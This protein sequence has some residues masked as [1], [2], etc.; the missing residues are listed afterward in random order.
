MAAKL[1]LSI[2]LL[3]CWPEVAMPRCR[4]KC[5]LYSGLLTTGSSFVGEEEVDIDNYLSLSCELCLR[6]WRTQDY[7]WPH[8]C[9]LRHG[10]AQAV[11]GGD[12]SDT[13]DQSPAWRNYCGSQRTCFSV[14]HIKKRWLETAFLR[15][16]PVSDA[17]LSLS[18]TSYSPA[19]QMMAGTFV[20]DV[21]PIG[22][23]T[24][25]QVG[26]PGLCWALTSFCL[27]YSEP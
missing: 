21:L 11:S 12:V 3:S 14:I 25:K 22:G 16:G 23:H 26:A 24:E 6:W 10:R 17:P 9:S 7:L 19:W 1:H 8:H 5:Y 20:P 2:L 15:I 18:F 27:G 13:H 4:K